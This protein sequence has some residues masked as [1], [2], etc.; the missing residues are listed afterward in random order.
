L[1]HLSRLFREVFKSASE[2]TRLAAVLFKNDDQATQRRGWADERTN[3][4]YC[5][6]AACS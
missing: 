4:T 1:A 6:L 2:A 5:E 3:A